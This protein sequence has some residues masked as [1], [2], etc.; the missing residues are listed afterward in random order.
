MASFSSTGAGKVHGDRHLLTDV[1]KGDLGFSGFVVS[2]WAGVDQVDPDYAT[3]VAQSI[4]RRHRHGHGPVRR[5]ALPGRGPRRARGR[6]DRRRRA[7]T[8]RCAESSTVKFELGLFETPM[9]AAPP[10][11]NAVGTA[12]HRALAREAVGQ[13]GGP[14]Q[15]DGRRAAGGRRGRADRP[16]G[17]LRRGRHRA[18]VGRLDDHVAGERR[19][20]HAR[21]DHRRR[22]DGPTGRSCPAD[23]VPDRLQPGRSRPTRH[24][25]RQRAAVRGGRRRLRDARPAGRATSLPSRRC[26]SACRASSIVV[27][28]SGRPVMLDEIL[29][30]ADVVD[31]RLAARAPRARASSTSCSATCRSPPR[32]RITWPRTPDDAPRTGK[33]PCDGAVFPRRLRAGGRRVAAGPGRLPVSEPVGQRRGSVRRIERDFPASQH[34]A[35][36][37]DA[38]RAAAGVGR[39]RPRADPGRGAHQ[40]AAGRL[41]RLEREAREVSI[42]CADVLMGADLGFDDWPSRVDAFLGDRLSGAPNLAQSVLSSGHLV[43]DGRSGQR[44]GGPVGPAQIP[45]PNHRPDRAPRT[46]MSDG[47]G[48]VRRT[49]PPCP[50]ISSGS[51]PYTSAPSRTR[52]TPSPPPSRPRRSRSSST[53]ATSWPAP[54]PGPAR[55]RP[56][57]CRCSSASAR[58]SRDRSARWLGDRSA[59][60]S[61]PRPVSS[62][63]RSRRASAST[64]QHSGIR[65]TAIYGGVG[66]APQVNALRRGVDVV[67][68]TPGRLLDHVGQRTIDLSEVE[69]LVLDE[70]DRML[71]MGF[72]RDIRR[73]LEVLPRER[74]NLLF[75]ATF[76][77]RD[78][79]R[80]RPASCT[81]PAS[82]QVTPRNS[83]APLVTQVVYPVDRERKRELLAHLI[84]TGVIDQALVFTRTKHGANKARRA[85]RPRR[86][87]GRRHPRQQEPGP[88]GPGARRLQVRSHADP[89][90][91]RDRRAR[92]R[93]RRPAARRQLR[94]ADGPRGLRPPHRA[95][96]AC[97]RDR[98]R[99]LARVRR[100]AQA[101]ARDRRRARRADPDRGHRGLRAR[102]LDPAGA[103]PAWR[104]GSRSTDRSASAASLRPTDGRGTGPASRSIAWPRLPARATTRRTGRA[105]P[106]SGR[107]QSSAERPATGRSATAWF[108]AARRPATAWPAASGT[109]GQWL[110]R[111]TA[112]RHGSSRRSRTTH[113]SAVARS[114]PGRPAA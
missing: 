33:A 24:R 99:R 32:R 109:P 98:P 102:S 94:A 8:M 84:R 12:A 82:V 58:P 28:L 23:R 62:R 80:W 3:A 7:S 38:R 67:V 18:P 42:D 34:A 113:R 20:D 70:A 25:G 76:S 41:D 54:R 59:P 14:A 66:F 85:A 56:S 88:A 104:P 43:L 114:T 44:P 105:R 17:R 6:D 60:S 30:I 36:R 110:E 53:A 10:D 75:S 112:C 50:S 21:H 96:R 52:A 48:P 49:V 39:R 13:I 77:E 46:T 91:D 57:C 72:I 95:D 51:R 101:A 83:A 37:A 40:R 61:S 86:H 74:Q 89:R 47:M 11:A 107:T 31:R 87:L 100:R 69:I 55:R 90:R 2:D 81:S 22:A 15:D 111:G 71:D 64:A 68:A 45:K 97:R 1:L 26:G 65:S 103:D 106:A 78:P 35:G 5:P 93:H 16:A 73:V 19:P 4:S 108:A 9:P 63:S 27:V 92:S 79:R 29:P